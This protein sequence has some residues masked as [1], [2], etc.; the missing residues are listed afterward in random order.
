[1]ETVRFAPK[2]DGGFFTTIV[3]R[4]NAYFEINRISPLA[5]TEMWIKTTIM[6]LLYFVPYML[7]VTG[8]AAGHA[9]LF[10]GLW[11]LMGWGMIGL[12]TAGMHDANH[13]TYSR[14]NNINRSIGSVLEIMGGLHGHMENTAQCI[15]SYLY[16][17]LPD[18]MKI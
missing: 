17:L 14:N 16:Q 8:F 13:G 3:A 2:V 1:M 7:L 5:N 10:F 6:F 4:V 9:W 15:T 18:W 11:F 12:G